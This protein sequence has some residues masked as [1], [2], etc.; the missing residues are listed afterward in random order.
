MGISPD[1][2]LKKMGHA[3]IKV[4]D[5]VTSVNIASGIR[6]ADRS[7]KF[8]ECG[9]KMML[10]LTGSKENSNELE[11]VALLYYMETGTDIQKNSSVSRSYDDSRFKNICRQMIFSLDSA[12]TDSDAENALRSIGIYGN[13]LDGIQRS[14]SIKGYKCMLKL[15]PGGMLMMVI[16]GI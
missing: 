8:L 10:V 15:Q 1:I 11:N 12:I 2:F 9:N 3:C 14:S 7:R 4:K 6:N 16:S 5:G 13:M